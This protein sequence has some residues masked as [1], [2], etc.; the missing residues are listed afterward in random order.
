MLFF[1]AAA[2]SGF[3]RRE[4]WFANEFAGGSLIPTTGNE[5]LNYFVGQRHGYDDGHIVDHAD[6]AIDVR[7]K[8]GDE[9][10]LRVTFR[11]AGQGD[12]AVRC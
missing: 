11:C 9:A 2:G 3:K 8:L 7:R 1:F 4:I 5:T 6:H 12:D 10:F